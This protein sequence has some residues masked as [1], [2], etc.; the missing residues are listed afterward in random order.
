MS[1]QFWPRSAAANWRPTLW[2]Y[3]LPAVLTACA[4]LAQGCAA[5][6]PQPFQGADA[7]NP[8]ARVPSA[9][10]RSVLGNYSSQRPVEPSPWR[11]SDERVAPTQKKDGQ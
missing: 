2:R 5:T 9:A 11:K 6:P 3:R 1:A 7:S 4:L 10:Y 8:D